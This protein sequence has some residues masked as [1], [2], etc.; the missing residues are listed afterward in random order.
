MNCSLSSLLR[1]PKWLGWAAG[2]ALAI[3]TSLA[4]LAYW[5]VRECRLI[6]EDAEW[7][8]RSAAEKYFKTLAILREERVAAECHL[9]R[10]RSLD[11]LYGDW[12][13][14]FEANGPDVE[15]ASS[16]LARVEA[17]QR[18]VDALPGSVPP[19][20]FA[21]LAWRDLWGAYL[22]GS[23]QTQER[24]GAILDS[25][26]ENQDFSPIAGSALL[27]FLD[28]WRASAGAQNDVVGAEM[29]ADGRVA[30][31][32]ATGEFQHWESHAPGLDDSA[33]PAKRIQAV[34][35]FLESLRADNAEVLLEGRCELRSY[36][37]G[38]DSYGLLIPED[39][40]APVVLSAHIIKSHLR[41][42]ANA[43]YWRNPR[44]PAACPMC[45][46]EVDAVNSG[47]RSILTP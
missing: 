17:E 14:R 27:G 47:K 32:L 11:R 41:G 42:S 13:Q 7:R 12:R 43:L 4:V 5:K 31:L 8:W 44:G 22:H 16:C 33:D 9:V 25:R 34:R 40:E 29:Q 30:R 3:G 23:N 46:A 45:Q 2:V 20:D 24:A 36:P 28:A 26:W 6:V 19:P 35:G 10:M 21:R 39:S 15:D 37:P 38:T 1:Q 18:V